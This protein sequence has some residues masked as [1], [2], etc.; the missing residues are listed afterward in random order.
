MQRVW[1]G[2]DSGVSVKKLRPKVC[3]HDLPTPRIKKLLVIA[4]ALFTQGSAAAAA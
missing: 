1:I 4:L 2:V 3:T